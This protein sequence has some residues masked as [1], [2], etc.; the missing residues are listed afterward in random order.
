LP[1]PLQIAYGGRGVG[2]AGLGWDVPFSYLQHRRT[3][4]HRRPA[5]GASVLPQPRQR[6]F[7]ALLG[8]ELELVRRG[9][10]RGTGW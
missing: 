4:A 7:I 2:A 5:Y 1:L 8:Q 10:P 9:K 6:T 3:F